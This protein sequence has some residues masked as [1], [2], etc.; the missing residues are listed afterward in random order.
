[1]PVEGDVHAEP[2]AQIVRHGAHI[3]KIAVVL[4]MPR[5]AAGVDH[6]IAGTGHVGEG[7]AERQVET[8][9]AGIL[10]IEKIHRELGE[11]DLQR[12]SA[13]AGGGL[14]AGGEELHRGE[15][16]AAILVQEPRGEPAD[17]ADRR[18]QLQ[19]HHGANAEAVAELAVAGGLVE[20]AGGERAVVDGIDRGAVPVEIGAAVEADAE[21]RRRGGRGEKGMELPPRR[22]RRKEEQ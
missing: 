7:G 17:A 14:R 22:C 11:A 8:R 6:R 16:R 21:A 5:G 10:E 1:M 19:P 4:P 12:G 2:R 13:L 3:L 9:Q 20:R 15:A 18:H